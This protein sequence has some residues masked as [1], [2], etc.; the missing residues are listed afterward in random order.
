MFARDLLEYLRAAPFEPF[1]VF[2]SDGSFFDIKHPEMVKVEKT[3]A[4]LFFH[5]RDEPYELVLRRLAISLLHINRI[6]P[7]AQLAGNSAST[8]NGKN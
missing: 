6:E 7:I 8:A 4:H 1:S 3:K 5:E 2:L